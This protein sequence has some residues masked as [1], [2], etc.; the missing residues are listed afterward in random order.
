MSLM[1]SLG[2]WICRWRGAHKWGRAITMPDSLW[3]ALGRPEP[4]P[5][6]KVCQRCGLV[7][8]IKPRT[9]KPKVEGAE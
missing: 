3:A 8:P 6:N 1:E 5:H 9:R 7:R 2:A 4:R